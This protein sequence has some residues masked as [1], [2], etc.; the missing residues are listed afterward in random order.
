MTQ[1]DHTTGSPP[2]L[3]EHA[4]DDQARDDASVLL[5]LEPSSPPTL[6]KTG[7]N[8]S[9]LTNLDS[10]PCYAPLLGTICSSGD[11]REHPKSG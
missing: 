7:Q 6:E 1:P 2:S 8:P 10:Q 11:V 5:G 4:A 9:D 3:T